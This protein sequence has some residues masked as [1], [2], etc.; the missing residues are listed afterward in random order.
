MLYGFG[1]SVASGRAISVHGSVPLPSGRSGAADTPVLTRERRRQT[2]DRRPSLDLS[3]SRCGIGYRSLGTPLAPRWRK[4]T[5]GRRLDRR[6]GT[7]N[8]GDSSASEDARNHPKSRTY[9]E[10]W[11]HCRILRILWSSRLFLRS[12]KSA[13]AQRIGLLQLSPSMMIRHRFRRLS[14]IGAAVKSLSPVGISTGRTIREPPP[15]GQAGDQDRP[16]R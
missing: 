14:D 11:A 16:R 15:S 2:D 1:P 7:A 12:R 5:R 3:S 10:A 6:N 9:G 8:G 13:A 4:G